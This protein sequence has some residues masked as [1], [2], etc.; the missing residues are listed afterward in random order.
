MRLSPGSGDPR[1]ALHRE[2]GGLTLRTAL[3]A[4]GLSASGGAEGC[5]RCEGSAP[6]YSPVSR[7]LLSRGGQSPG[8]LGGVS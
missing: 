3:V 8:E 1:S 5:A 4:Y 6:E 2:A 7:A